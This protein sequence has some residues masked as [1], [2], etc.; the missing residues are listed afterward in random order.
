MKARLAVTL[1]LLAASVIAQEA[2]PVPFLRKSVQL[3]DGQMAAVERGEVVTRLLPT[4]DKAEVAAFGVVKVTGDAERLLRLAR[5][6]RTFRKG[7]RVAEI[8]LFATPPRVEDLV[9][10]TH[11]PDDIAALR[12]CRPGECDVKLGTRGLDL[13]ARIDWSA[14]DAPAR[15]AAIFNEGIVA[16]VAAYQKS[17][18]D[19]LG[20]VVDKK[21]ARS[22]AQEYRALLASSPYLQEYVRELADYLAAYPQKRLAGAE[23]AFYWTKDTSGPKPVVSGWHTTAWRGPHG[24]VVANRLLGATHFFNAA[25][26][27][28]AAVP[29][30]DGKGL[31][32][33]SLHRTRLDPPTGM[34]AGVLMGKVKDG[35]VAGVRES[36]ET[37][38]GRLAASR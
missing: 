35:V 17:G 1:V 25:L 15:A 11:P 20:D 14:S 13:I 4:A 23:D 5:D 21:N 3:D 36:L 38:R 31:Y 29:T 7:P 26:D 28:L 32:L 9:G 2:P 12:K 6:V 27:L 16:Y 10:L 19:A 8:G 37:A 24:V 34:L 18:V 22:R 33:M 30:P